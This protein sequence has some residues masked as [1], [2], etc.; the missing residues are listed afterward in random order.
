MR[1]VSFGRAAVNLP[2][3]ASYKLYK[4]T[5]RKLPITMV[6]AGLPQIAELAGDAKSYAERLFTFPAINNLSPS[7]SKAALS[8]SA[9]GEDVTFTPQALDAA[10][11]RHQAYLRIASRTTS[12]SFG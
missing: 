7:H 2:T 4:M 10:V 12:T 11:N 6:G 5:Q 3:R 9:A 8:Q 1:L